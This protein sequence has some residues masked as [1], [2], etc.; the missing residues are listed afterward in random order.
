MSLNLKFKKIGVQIQDGPEENTG[1]VTFFSNIAVPLC[2]LPLAGGSG[3]LLLVE[4]PLDSS[5]SACR[6]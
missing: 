5:G 3:V 2:Y 4:M 1:N 6:Y